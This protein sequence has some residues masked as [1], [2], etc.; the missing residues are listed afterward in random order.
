MKTKIYG[1]RGSKG[2]YPEN[3]MLGFRKAIETGVAGMEIDIHMT[4]DREIVVLHD[5]TLTRT[6]TGS[7]YIK[8]LTL[9]EI[10]QFRIGPKFKYFKKYEKSWDDEIIPTL[11][12][13]LELFKQHDLEVNIELK[14][15][16]IAYPGMEELMFE[17]VKESGYN[18]D[19]VIY[20]SFHIP[21]MLKLREV[22]P[23]AKLAFLIEVDFHRIYDY[24]DALGL[25]SLHPGKDLVLAN[26]GLWEPL[27]DKLRI[28][29]VNDPAQMQALIDMGVKAII[30]DYPEIAEKLV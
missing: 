29:T 9:E 10:R 12:E 19:K 1:H 13:A 23:L 25:E 20:S 3:S 24:F 22:N 15:C 18:P 16:E 11:A 5:S 28:W 14:T 30:T 2:S 17:I 7:G 6:S 4:K 27:A 21:T 26:P 8:D